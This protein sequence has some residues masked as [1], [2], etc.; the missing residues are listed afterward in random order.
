MLRCRIHVGKDS[1]VLSQVDGAKVVQI[2][3]SQLRLVLIPE[4]LTAVGS[5]WQANLTALFQCFLKLLTQAKWK[6]CG[7]GSLSPEHA[8]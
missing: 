1:Q 7:P 4:L 8:L 2:G 5:Y 3:A 6:A